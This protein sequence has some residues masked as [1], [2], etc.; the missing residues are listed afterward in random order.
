MTPQDE[1]G[2]P[3]SVSRRVVEFL[4]MFLYGCVIAAVVK[5]VRNY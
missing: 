1:P 5:Y 3:I 4:L 2:E